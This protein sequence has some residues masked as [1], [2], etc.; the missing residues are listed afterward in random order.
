MHGA[1]TIV[2]GWLM[3]KKS[4]HVKRGPTS[5]GRGSRPCSGEDFSRRAKQDLIR[6]VSDAV[7]QRDLSQTEAA[8][9]C[10]TTQSAF[11]S[12]VLGK[13]KHVT[14]DRLVRWIIALGG[15]VDVRATPCDVRM[16]TWQLFVAKAREEAAEAGGVGAVS[17]QGGEYFRP[18]GGVK[19]F[20]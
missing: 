2:L 12:V 19:I 14:I 13:E 5:Q 4:E 9:L 6:V 11:S 20:V 18:K 8:V 3:A 17:N 10:G 7:K 15:L 16:K 1:E